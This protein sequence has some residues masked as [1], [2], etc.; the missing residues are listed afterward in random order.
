MR[1]PTHSSFRT[2]ACPGSHRAARVRGAGFRGAGFRG[3]RLEHPELHWYFPIARPKV[4]GGP[5]RLRPGKSAELC[6][7]YLLPEA[8]D[9]TG[10][11]DGAIALMQRGIAAREER[12]LHQANHDGLTGLPNRGHARDRLAAHA[13][14]S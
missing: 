6:F 1:R 14:S 2:R 10:F 7:V 5:E 11:P 9:F 12:I 3:A 13:Q 8:E 4:S